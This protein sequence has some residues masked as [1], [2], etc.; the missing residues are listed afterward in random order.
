MNT[1]CRTH[2]QRH[3]KNPKLLAFILGF[4]L[5]PCFLFNL[6]LSMMWHLEGLLMIRHQLLPPCLS[7]CSALLSCIS[8]LPWI[9]SHSQS[10]HS[11]TSIWPGDGA[12]YFSMSLSLHSPHSP[13]REE[14]RPPVTLG[15]TG[16]PSRLSTTGCAV[17]GLCRGTAG[18]GGVTLRMWMPSGTP[19][20]RDFHSN[21]WL[22]LFSGLIASVHCVWCL[23]YTQSANFQGI[24][25]S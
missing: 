16:N 23:V 18:G 12:C 9:H 4:A 5:L 25:I 10:P 13:D 20:R 15:K 14:E 21:F 11:E 19:C 1:I 3:K 6:N 22:W 8:H 7:L 24:L 17:H 2:L